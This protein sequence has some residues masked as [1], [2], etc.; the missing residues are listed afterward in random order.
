MQ[1]KLNTGEIVELL[2]GQPEEGDYYKI[3][4]PPGAKLTVNCAFLEYVG[5]VKPK[6]PVAI[7]P[8]SG[9]E[10]TPVDL[11]ASSETE[12]PVFGN[13]PKDDASSADK[14]ESDADPAAAKE[15]GGVQQDESSQ[16]EAEEAS[17]NLKACYALSARIDLE[18]QKPLEEQ[19]YDAIKKEAKVIKADT[20]DS[21]AS[22]FAQILLDR[23]DGIELAISVP[24]TLKE[25]D[26]SLAETKEKIEKAHEEELESV[27]RDADFIYTGVLKISHV[28]TQKTGNKRYLVEDPDG[29]ILC[30]AVPASGE[31]AGQFES[32]LGKRVGVRGE[33]S[34]D[35]KSLVTLIT[36]T[37]VE[38]I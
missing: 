14:P 27:H 31:V 4:A 19:N 13:L 35:T 6:K 26:E 12:A 30:Y 10:K 15:T 18:I 34:S 7:P 24:D 20:T 17:E 33:V 5:P 1:T 21:K 2:P 16:P 9:V 36:A 8:R 11:P 22:G 28:Y 32:L 38:P 3:K 25:Q 23:I 29:K 37:A